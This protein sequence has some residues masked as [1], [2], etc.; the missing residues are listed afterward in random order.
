MLSSN[1]YLPPP[2]YRFLHAFRKLF[3]RSLNTKLHADKPWDTYF[4][5]I[6]M[7]G[8]LSLFEDI[9]PDRFLAKEFLSG[10]S[11]VVYA[12]N[13]RSHQKEFGFNFTESDIVAAMY[14]MSR[15]LVL[16]GNTVAAAEIDALL[17]ETNKDLE[18]CRTYIVAVQSQTIQKDLPMEAY[19]TQLLYLALNAFEDYLEADEELSSFPR[20]MNLQASQHFQKWENTRERLAGKELKIVN[21]A[22]H[23][24]CHH[25]PGDLDVAKVLKAMDVACSA[26]AKVQLEAAK[27][28]KAMDPACPAMAKAEKPATPWEKISAA[29]TGTKELVSAAIVI[30]CIN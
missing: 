8:F 30:D 1:S 24:Y 11:R 18:K 22:R 20:P 3:S 14:H 4:I 12:R 19:N 27:F 16:T 15:V 29:T 26:M 28:W 23:W 7:E 9:F 21:D 13:V 25:L 10:I 6:V 2:P 17:E 5:V